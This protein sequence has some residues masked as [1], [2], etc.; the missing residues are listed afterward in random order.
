[1]I[2]RFRLEQKSHYERLVIAQRL[3]DMLEKFL[4]GR[5][6]PLPLALNRVG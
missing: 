6:L 5:P 3:S 2:K 4:D 1:M